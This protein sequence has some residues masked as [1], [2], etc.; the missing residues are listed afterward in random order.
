MP[1][2]IIVVGILI[3]GAALFVTADPGAKLWL[4]EVITRLAAWST[5]E[6]TARAVAQYAA[7]AAWKAVY[8]ESRGHE[9]SGRDARRAGNWTPAAAAASGESQDAAVLSGTA[10]LESEAQA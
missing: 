1:D 6:L 9:S 4:A 8:R 3:V 2:P 10:A 5:R 7:R